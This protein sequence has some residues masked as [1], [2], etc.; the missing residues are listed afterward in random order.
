LTARRRARQVFEIGIY[1]VVAAVVLQFFLAG[2]GIFVSGEFFFLHATAGALV[3]GIGPLLLAGIGWYGGVDRR[4]VLIAASFFLLVVLQSLLMAPY[5][6]GAQGP[7]RAIS[8]LHV[9][10]AIFI[11]WVALQ[12]LDRVRYPRGLAKTIPPVPAERRA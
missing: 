5:H 3:I 2:M 12:L 8:A 4:T 9:V 11:F 7:L 10:N 6:M 1:V